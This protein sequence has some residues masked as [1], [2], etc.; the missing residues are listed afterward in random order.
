M[1]CL[2][3]VTKMRII[4]ALIKFTCANNEILIF[5]KKIFFRLIKCTSS[6]LFIPNAS[7]SEWSGKKG[8]FVYS[9]GFVA[10]DHVIGTACAEGEILCT[11]QAHTLSPRCHLKL[12][13]WF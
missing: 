3:L 12:L 13:L 1:Y 11:P 2:S 6:H 10:S 7:S 5:G 9:Y 8:H 4:T